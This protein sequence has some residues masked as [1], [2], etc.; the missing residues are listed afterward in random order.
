MNMN[1]LAIVGTWDENGGK[2]SSLASKILD[3]TGTIPEENIRNGGNYADL[4]NLNVDNYDVI[5]WWPNIPNELPKLVN[6]IKKKNPHCILCISKQITWEFPL[7]SISKMLQNSSNLMVEFIK[8]KNLF[9]MRLVDPLGNCFFYG[10][11]PAKL[12][13][14]LLQRLRFIYKLTRLPSFQ[15]NSVPTI[16]KNLIDSNFLT[17]VK[18]Y[19]MVVG[20]ETAGTQVNADRFFGNC[21]FRCM[22]GFPAIRTNKSIYISKRNVDKR[23]I[24]E[25][26]FISCVK[27]SRGIAYSG[28][29][30][31]SVDSPI[32]LELFEQFPNINYIMHFHAYLREYYGK[33]IVST[34]ECVPCGCLEEAGYIK[35]VLCN[36]KGLNLINLKGHGCIITSETTD[37]LLNLQ[38]KKRPLYEMQ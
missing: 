4:I 3:G 9:N 35:E 26:N 1:I 16:D 37:Q 20:N 13:I 28:D 25:N 23:L 7:N 32:I 12:M 8:E 27:T 22:A 31:P 24:D 34:R 2:K 38:F 36:D 19:A 29:C 5:L 21:S 30:K 33:S 6:T 14:I 18:Y 10:S 17:I 11:D 15:D